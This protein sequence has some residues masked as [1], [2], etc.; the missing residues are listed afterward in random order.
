[1]L[2][3]KYTHIFLLSSLR[4]DYGIIGSKTKLRETTQEITHDLTDS[5][6]L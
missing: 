2:R 1:M 3:A 4:K 6:K 5:D